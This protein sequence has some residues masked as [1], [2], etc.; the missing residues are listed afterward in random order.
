MKE[1]CENS[2]CENPA[3][4]EVPVSARS[5]SDDVRTLCAPCEE[6]YTWGVQHGV[7]SAVSRLRFN[8]V[9]QLLEGQ[10]FVVL[11]ENSADPSPD[12]A[13]ES[14]AYK[15]ALDFEVAEPICFGIGTH[16]IDALRAL[17]EQLHQSAT[18]RLRP[19]MRTSLLTSK[20]EL[21]AILAGLRL[22]QAERLQDTD[23]AAGEAIREIATDA[24]LFE[25]LSSDEIGE[26]CERLNLDEAVVSPQARE[27]NWRDASGLT[28]VRGV[29]H[30]PQC[31]RC[32][33]K[34]CGCV[35]HDGSMTEGASP[36]EAGER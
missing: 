5:P 4:K 33:S 14:W 31:S 10:G 13:F 25:P 28:T 17:D 22:Y 1:H 6:A 18:P 7:M 9:D 35:K 16:S 36:P 26:L 24:G 15:G 19:P 2:R 3:H 11:A 30:R 29:E 34:K 20:R 12:G 8:Q 21:A 23:S 27:H 32:G